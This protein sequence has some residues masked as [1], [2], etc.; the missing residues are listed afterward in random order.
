MIDKVRHFF[1]EAGGREGLLSA[2]FRRTMRIGGDVETDAYALNAWIAR[3]IVKSREIP[4]AR[5]PLSCK[6]RTSDLLRQVA[7]L[8]WSEQGP[9]L[10][11]EFL[12]NEGIAL[13]I[14]DRMPRTHLDGAA[15]VDN[16]DGTPIVGLTI[17]HD[18]IDN[19]WFTL[20]HE[21]AHVSLHLRNRQDA[22]VDNTDDDPDH[23]KEELEA[24]QFAREALIPRSEWRRSDACRLQ[25]E[26]A[27][28]K[29]AR[30]LRIHP[31]IIVG[32]IRKETGNYK[33]LPK[34]IGQGEVGRLF[35]K[36][37]KQQ[38]KESF[39]VPRE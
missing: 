27:V 5:G 17:R 10:A 24:N 2:Y 34:L 36:R 13:V 15:L 9:L 32:R 7:Q 3:V 19:F 33:R 22:F 29:L 4:M 35:G 6:M 38:K 28:F 30:E 23:D 21:L 37:K 14:E 12:A 11:K 25:T 26:E 31:A 8:S 18:R 39:D 16:V 20:L 1:A